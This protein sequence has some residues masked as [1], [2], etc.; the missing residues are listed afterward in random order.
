MSSNYGLPDPSRVNLNTASQRDV[1]CYMLATQNTYD[2]DLPARI[3]SVFVILIVSSAVTFF[4]VMC[5]RI[6]RLRIP[7]YVYLF[8]RYFGA[9]VIIATGFVQSVR[10]RPQPP[11]RA[12]SGGDPSELC[13]ADRVLAQS[14]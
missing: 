7:L 2:G 11:A 13:P 10:P 5:M 9:G 6:P 4:P 14:S 1:F 8:A 3:S 12:A